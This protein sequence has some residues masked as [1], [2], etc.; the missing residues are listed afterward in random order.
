MAK[1]IVNPTSAGRREMVLPR[2]LLSIG[3]DPSNDLVLPDAMVSRRHAVIELRGGQYFLRDSSS[4]NGSLVNGDRVTERSLRDGDLVAIGTARLLFR[5]DVEVLDGVGKVVQHPSAPRLHCP[6]CSA[7]YRRGDVFCR[8]CGG[9]LPSGPAKLVCTACGSAVAMPAR[10]CNACG[11]TLPETPQAAGEPEGDVVGPTALAPL[12]PGLALT[13]PQPGEPSGPA[14]AA[15]A[16]GPTEV[17]PVLGGPAHELPELEL[18]PLEPERAPGARPGGVALAVGSTPEPSWRPRPTLVVDK[19]RSRLRED[20]T[21]RRRSRAAELAPRAAAGLFDLA[22]VGLQQVLLIAPAVYYWWGR[23]LATGVSFGPVLLSVALP[24]LS[25]ALS[26]LYFVYFWGVRGAT[27]GKQL[28]GLAVE[29]LDGECPIGL[30]R[31]AARLLGY[32]LS[33]ALLGLGFVMIAITG[34]GLHDRIAGTRV[35]RREVR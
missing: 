35:V 18:V 34:D 12:E 2:T 24:L 15:S 13:P 25:L 22:L 30:G 1:L 21:D 8:Q 23:D 9:R 27:P 11:E 19:K 17:A 20:Q 4:S 33:A 28:A 32:V 6:A 14:V 31:A 5:D 10:F 26:T 29:S 3:R 16:S 7:D